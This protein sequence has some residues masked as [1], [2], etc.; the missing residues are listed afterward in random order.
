[1]DR[2]QANVSTFSFFYHLL[3][4]ARG[5]NRAA[6]AEMEKSNSRGLIWKQRDGF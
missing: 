3:F 5:E 2:K 6:H 4:P 1:M